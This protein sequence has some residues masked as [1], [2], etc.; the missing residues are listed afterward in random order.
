MAKHMKPIKAA[1]E[2]ELVALLNEADMGK[3]VLLERHGVVYQL[4]KVDDPESIRYEP[5]AEAV[6]RMLDEVAGSWADLDTDQMVDDIY[7]WREA[8]TRP[9]DRP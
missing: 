2:S 5:D 1:S 8:G 4:R 6:R 7:R 3:P 9:P